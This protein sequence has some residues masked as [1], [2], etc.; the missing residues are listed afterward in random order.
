MK[1]MSISVKVITR[2]TLG[3]IFLF[4]FYVFVFSRKSHGV[5]FAGGLIISL[6]LLLFML[7]YGKE[8]VEKR[9]NQVRLAFMK[10]VFLLIF[11]ALAFVV[12]FF[13]NDLMDL[14]DFKLVSILISVFSNAALALVS[15]GCFFLMFLNLLSFKKKSH[16]E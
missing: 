16:I 15:A 4:G 2:L 7:A 3:V 6:G 14:K 9:I 5:G 10:D 11:S 13:G 12:V 8:A 1:G